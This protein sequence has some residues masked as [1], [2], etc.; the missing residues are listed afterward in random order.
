MVSAVSY[1]LGYAAPS[2]FTAMLKR[3]FGK[4]PRDHQDLRRS[5]A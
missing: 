2:A 3:V 4:S 1:E 5:L